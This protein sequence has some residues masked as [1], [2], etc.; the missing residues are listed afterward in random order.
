MKH[1]KNLFL[2]LFLT[3]TSLCFLFA[4]P[5]TPR[6]NCLVLHNEYHEPAEPYNFGHR[7]WSS[8]SGEWVSEGRTHDC[9]VGTMNAM[10]SP[11]SC[12]SSEKCIHTAHQP[13]YPIPPTT[14]PL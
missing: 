6:A 12:P 8:H 7:C 11:R 2:L 1:Y 13:L 5:V 14:P 10:C 3:I 4:D 9:W